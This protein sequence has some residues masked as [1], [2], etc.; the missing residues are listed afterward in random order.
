MYLKRL[1]VPDRVRKIPAGFS[2]IDRRFVRD[3]F[4]R[5]L[6]ESEILLYYFLVSVAD[7]QGLSYWSDPSIGKLLHHE[8]IGIAMAR[9]RLIQ[10]DLL[11]YSDP[12]Y[13]VLSL[14]EVGRHA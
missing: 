14:P 10:A 8:P 7:A 6:D 11:A 3:G 12:L 9:A 4:L 5:R 1:L 2:W 13:Q